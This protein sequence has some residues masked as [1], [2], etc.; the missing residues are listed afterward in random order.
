[1]FTQLPETINERIN[2][3]TNILGTGRE[4]YIKACLKFPQLFVLSPETIKGKFSVLTIYFGDPQKAREKILSEPSV[5]AHSKERDLMHYFASLIVKPYS[6]NLYPNPE[7]II[8]NYFRKRG[9]PQKGEE[10][11]S[12]IKDL[13]KDYTQR[14]KEEA[15]KQRQERFQAKK[16]SAN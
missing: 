12:A 1:M 15:K 9:E 14:E 4:E 11:I 6:P 13:Y 3:A 7:N 2:K 5:L 8:L 10:V 16:R